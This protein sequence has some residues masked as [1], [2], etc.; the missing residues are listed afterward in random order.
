MKIDTAQKMEYSIKDFLIF[1]A[2]WKKT[3]GSGVYKVICHDGSYLLSLGKGKL[4]SF[5]VSH[6]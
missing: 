3:N 4:Q 1:C 5:G 2:V 6:Q